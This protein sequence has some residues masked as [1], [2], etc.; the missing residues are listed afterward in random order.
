MCRALV[1]PNCK[2]PEMPLSAKL[3]KWAGLID[4]WASARLQVQLVLHCLQLLAGPDRYGQAPG[5]QIPSRQ[6]Q[7]WRAT[8]Y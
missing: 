7:K 1:D 8:T 3:C 5:T 6:K 2:V 4:I